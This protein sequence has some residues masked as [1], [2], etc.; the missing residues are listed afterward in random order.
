[1]VSGYVWVGMMVPEL[2]SAMEILV[3]PLGWQW[4]QQWEAL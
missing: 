3:E 2:E 4:E 1:M